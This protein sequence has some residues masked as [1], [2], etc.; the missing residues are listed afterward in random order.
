VALPDFIK[1]YPKLATYWANNVI[2]N[3]TRKPPPPTCCLCVA[4]FTSAAICEARMQAEPLMNSAIFFGTA[5]AQITPAMAGGE[6]HNSN[7]L[8]LIEN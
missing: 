5:E 1:V 3:V 6:F 8:R 2:T 4:P 7:Y